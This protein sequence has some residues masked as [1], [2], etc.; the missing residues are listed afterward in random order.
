MIGAEDKIRH[1]F[2]LHPLQRG[3]VPI[4]HALR[5]FVAGKGTFQ[6]FPGGQGAQ[7]FPA[8]VD[9]KAVAGSLGHILPPGSPVH[10]Q[11]FLVVVG[12]VLGGLPEEGQV[13]VTQRQRQPGRYQPDS[14]PT[15]PS[16]GATPCG[17][18]AAERSQRQGCQQGP[19]WHEQVEMG[20]GKL[21]D[22]QVQDQKRQKPEDQQPRAPP[23]SAPAQDEPYRYQQNQ[24]AEEIDRVVKGAQLHK[25]RH[26]EGADATQSTAQVALRPGKAG[27]QHTRQIGDGHNKDGD[28]GSRQGQLGNPPLV[29]RMPPAL[30][31]QQQQNRGH[32]RE[33]VV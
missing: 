17:R 20:A 6:T 16:V 8:L 10:R 19:A 33:L 5:A 23:C 22:E 13:Q 11:A 7:G 2:R 21:H 30:P 9:G 18:P 27:V 12:K 4:A 29:G 32:Q 25:D 31:G 1:G 28:D 15:Q 14:S 26:V 24:A 3:Q